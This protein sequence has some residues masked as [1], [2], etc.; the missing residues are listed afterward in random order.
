[1]E[2]KIIILTKQI[3]PSKEYNREYYKNNKEK[4]N[5]QRNLCVLKKRIKVL[6]S[7]LTRNQLI[8]YTNEKYREWKDILGD[9]FDCNSEVL[10]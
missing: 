9:D 10:L 3:Q 6:E 1:M 7:K 5:L 2:E 4:R 8:K